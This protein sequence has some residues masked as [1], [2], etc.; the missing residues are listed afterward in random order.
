MPGISTILYAV[1]WPRGPNKG[2][3]P[4]TPSSPACEANLSGHSPSGLSQGP[5][6]SP[7]P[8][9]ILEPLRGLPPGLD[10][11][12]ALPPSGIFRSA[13]ALASHWISRIDL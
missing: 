9:L 10:L 4:V 12:W 1:A 13:P 11:T 8:F 2:N 5:G 3:G 6:P 7:G